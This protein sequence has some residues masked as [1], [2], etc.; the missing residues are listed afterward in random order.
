LKWASFDTLREAKPTKLKR[1]IVLAWFGGVKDYGE[2]YNTLIS[3]VQ[4]SWFSLTDSD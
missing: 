3:E 1:D 4:T 2:L